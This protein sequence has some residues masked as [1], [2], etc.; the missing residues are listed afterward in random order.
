MKEKQTKDLKNM[1]NW[2]SWMIGIILVDIF[3]ADIIINRIGETPFILIFTVAE[4]ATSIGALV[5]SIIYV[6]RYKTNRP[7]AITFLVISSL[8]VVLYALIFG[9]G[10]LLGI[11]GVY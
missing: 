7:L 6:K 5:T 1:K 3:L 10:F 4:V 2:F 8:L 11:M 9:A